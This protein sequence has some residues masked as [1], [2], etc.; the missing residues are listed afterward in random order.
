MGWDVVAITNKELDDPT[1]M[2]GIAQTIRR[3]LG[4]RS[5]RSNDTQAAKR[6]E[7]RRTLGLP[8]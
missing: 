8:S 2:D 3:R 5:R 1:A 4:I 7:L 6:L